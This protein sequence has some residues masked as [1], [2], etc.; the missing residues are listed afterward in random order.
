[1][2]FGSHLRETRLLLPQKVPVGHAAAIYEHAAVG[3]L[4]G[5]GIAPEIVDTY[6]AQRNSQCSVQDDRVILVID[7][8]LVEH[9]H[10]LNGLL[11]G[12]AAR[13]VVKGALNRVIAEECYGA[14]ELPWAAVFLGRALACKAVLRHALANGAHGLDTFWQILTVIGHECGHAVP[15][16]SELSEVLR[17][18]ARLGISAEVTAIGGR[19]NASLMTI[20]RDEGHTAPEVELQDDLLR[21]F[22]AGGGP[23]DS[24]LLKIAGDERFIAEVACDGFATSVVSDHIRRTTL[25]DGTDGTDGTDAEVLKDVLLATYRTFLNMRLHQYVSD[26]ARS[27][28][29]ASERSGSD[30]LLRGAYE[31]SIRGRLARQSIESIWEGLAAAVSLQGSQFIDFPGLL[32]QAGAEHDQTLLLPARELLS[33]TLLDNGFRACVTQHLDEWGFDPVEFAQ[34]P[35]SARNSVERFWVLVAT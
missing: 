29:Q 6:S 4:E 31:L 12:K 23:A 32:A 14:G 20:L 34:D 19:I 30:A 33:E 8:A 22:N 28:F 24:T 5:L 25:A 21:D 11:R 27:A 15:A 7:H 2:D 10:L 18:G 35:W 1:M 17:T 16:G 26:V 3:V 13:E 9:F